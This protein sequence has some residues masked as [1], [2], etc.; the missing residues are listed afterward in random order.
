MAGA[1]FL[2]RGE[3][4][5]KE[6]E[7]IQSVWVIQ[8]G[9]ISLCLQKNKK[10]VDIMSVGIGYV[11][12]DLIV[13]G[14]T[15]YNFSAMATQETKVAEIP[16]D[17]FKQQFDS[18]HQVNKSFVKGLSEKLKYTMSEVRSA[19]F[20][21]DPSACPEDAVAKV[22]GTLFHVMNHKG[23]KE[24]TSAKMD[25][26]TMRQYSQRIFGESIKRLEQA[27]QLLVK[28]KLANYIY[29]KNPD[30][31]NAKDEIQGFFVHDLSAIEAFFEFYQYYYYKGSKSELL[32]FDESNY[33]FLRLLVL[34]LDG[35]EA[36]RFGIVSKD[37]GEVTE[38][39]K[40]YGVN[41]GA[42]HFTSLEGKGLFCKRKV[43]AEGKVLL[44]FEIKEF[45]TQQNIWKIIREI[46]KWNEKGMID[47]LDV[48]EGPKKKNV[49]NGTECP[50]CHIVMV[51]NSKFC[52]ECGCKL[53]FTGAPDEVEKKAA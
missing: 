37:L 23:L 26:Q 8:S 35:V 24:G 44:Q 3:Y 40:S 38:F 9:Q 13:L 4:L 41:M 16:L 21:K 34:A 7:K 36:D 49:V 22:F 53:A 1:K 18:L 17:I 46:D 19:R 5:F 6:G 47:M 48:D 31:P 29:G 11:F 52:S 42:G 50:E 28:L 20:E 43:V 10:N 25:W 30:D 51:A 33:N 39:V 27:T 45:K 15:N 32:K 14:L 12:G 2:K